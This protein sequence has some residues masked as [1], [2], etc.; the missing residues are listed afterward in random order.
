[1]LS[2][3]RI[4]LLRLRFSG[5]DKF[6]FI[7]SLSSIIGHRIMLSIS[8]SRK[9][10]GLKYGEPR[11]NW[12]NNQTE[13]ILRVIFQKNF[14]SRTEL[15]AWELE[16]SGIV[17]MDAWSRTPDTSR[18]LIKLLSGQSKPKPMGGRWLDP[19]AL[20]SFQGLCF[21]PFHECVPSPW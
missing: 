7:Y 13:R 18:L 2:V 10:T 12:Y 4:P 17:G 3:S 16:K 11:H 1:M 15:W 19:A 21:A 8:G 6:G 20:S 14:F 5:G 9:L